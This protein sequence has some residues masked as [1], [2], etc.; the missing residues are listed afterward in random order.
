MHIPNSKHLEL[1]EGKLSVK[2]LVGFWSSVCTTR[3]GFELMQFVRHSNLGDVLGGTGGFILGR[4][5]DT[6]MMASLSFFRRRR[7]PEGLPSD[8]FYPFAPDLAVEVLR[9]HDGSSD[10]VRRQGVYDKAGVPLVWWIDTENQLAIVRRHGCEPRT[11]EPSGELHGEG[12]LE[13]L[14]IQLATIF[15]GN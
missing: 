11:V 15:D 8:G 3:L 7:F 6:V 14:R 1:I 5:P 12:A 9:A 13:G 10:M 4:D 2:P